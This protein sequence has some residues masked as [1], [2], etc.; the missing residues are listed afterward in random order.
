MRHFRKL[1]YLGAT[2]IVLHH[3]GKSETSKQYRGSSDI[4]AAVDIA[5]LLERPTQQPEE[6]PELS[7]NCFKARLAP[8]R[9]FGMRFQQ[10]RGF[11][12]TDA[13]RTTTTVTEIIVEI[14]RTNPDC[15]QRRAIEL[16]RG[17]GCSKSQ[18]ERCL[19]DGPWLKR[20]GPNNS[21]LYNLPPETADGE[22]R[23]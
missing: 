14:L 9:D 1:A 19:K 2:V 16:G 15:N 12:C 18:I 23:G 3:T 8:G 11:E 13:F 22:A 4:K 7:M 10:G 17:M 21:I 5:Y 20:T 6:L